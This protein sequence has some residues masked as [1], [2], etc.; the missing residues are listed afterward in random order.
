MEQAEHSSAVPAL[1]GK[2]FHRCGT[3]LGHHR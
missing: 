3:Q 2:K 1:I